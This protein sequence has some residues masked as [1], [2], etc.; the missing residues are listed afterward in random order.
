MNRAKNELVASITRAKLE[1]DDA[2]E[3]LKDLPMLDPMVLGFIG[4]ALGNYLHVS[5]GTIKLLSGVLRNHPQEEVSIWLKGLQDITTRMGNLINA[6][7]ARP[8]PTA[9]H[10]MVPEIRFDQVDLVTL[11]RRCCDFYRRPAA[12][13]QIEL[14]F[15]T[16]SSPPLKVRTDRIAV[17]A[18]LDNLLSNAVNLAAA[19]G[20]I[21]VEVSNEPGNVVCR[22]RNGNSG[23]SSED[24]ASLLRRSAALKVKP[25]GDGYS[26]DY[27]VAVAA[28]LVAH[29]GGEFGSE[30]D[31]SRGACFFFRLPRSRGGGG[32]RQR[33]K[34]PK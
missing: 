32:A 17:A 5:S 15:E 10:K 24:R 11:V 13:K 6:L 23:F 20:R 21:F 8:Q 29:L 12:R 28:E 34:R 19:G 4:H 30:S 1:L 2:L 14:R 25:R 31:R 26:A 33:A 3:D 7:Q 27:G 16:S 9:L 18:I 22:V